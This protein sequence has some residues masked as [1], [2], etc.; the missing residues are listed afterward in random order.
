MTE[1]EASNALHRFLLGHTSP[2]TPAGALSYGERRRLSLALLILGGANLL[3]LDEPT[4][5]LDLPS[6]EA[7]ERALA[8][9]TGAVV[10]VTHDRRSIRELVCDVLDLGAYAAVMTAR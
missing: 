5:H 1:R 4:N 8:G 10:A 2:R 7:F 9:F 3:L 6:R